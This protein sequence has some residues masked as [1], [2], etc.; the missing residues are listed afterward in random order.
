MV[1]P[2]AAP[3]SVFRF[4]VKVLAGIRN[5]ASR[6]LEYFTAVCTC[7]VVSQL[8]RAVSSCSGFNA[9]LSVASLARTAARKALKIAN[10]KTG[11]SRG[12]V[13]RG[14]A[15]TVYHCV[16]G[17]SDLGFGKSIV[18]RCRQFGFYCF[19]FDLHV[20]LVIVALDSTEI[21][22][23][24]VRP[25]VL[26]AYALGK[27]TFPTVL[28]LIRLLLD[29]IASIQRLGFDIQGKL[30]FQGLVVGHVHGGEVVV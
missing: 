8:S 30:V 27:M 11:C 16:R 9:G 12:M 22:G 26:P 10:Q 25:T 24:E 15:G 14:I 4:P 3:L 20:R 21:G 6:L 29:N 18:A 5:T 28:E 13:G 23:H 2:F 7:F 17:G 1:I 19:V